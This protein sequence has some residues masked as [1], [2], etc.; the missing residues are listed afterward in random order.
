MQRSN[1]KLVGEKG[2]SHHLVLENPDT[3]FGQMSGELQQFLIRN[4]G[5]EL[6]T[7]GLHPEN[8]GLKS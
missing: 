3:G 5:T 4:L 8:C 2:K 1:G 6:R 7:G